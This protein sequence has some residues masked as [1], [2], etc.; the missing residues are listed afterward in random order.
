[1]KAFQVMLW[2]SLVY[3][4]IGVYGYVDKGSAT[5]LISP[6]IGIIL[7]ILVFPTKNDNS[8]AAHI[9][10]GLTAL[11]TI[12]FFITAFLRDSSTI[13]ILAIV[14]LVAMILYIIDFKRRKRE[15]EGGQ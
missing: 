15:R 13:L 7:F 4:I 14:S 8:T 11:S 5:A 2:T 3:I 1:M 6:A 9:G 12:A 10:I